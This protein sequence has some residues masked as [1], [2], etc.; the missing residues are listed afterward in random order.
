MIQNTYWNLKKSREFFFFLAV[1]PPPLGKIPYFFLGFFFHPSLIRMINNQ[2]F[3]QRQ[4]PKKIW[5]PHC[6]VD[7]LILIFTEKIWFKPL[8]RARST[9]LSL[10]ILT[11]TLNTMPGPQQVTTSIENIC[12][13]NICIQ[14]KTIPVWFRHSK[15]NF[16]ISQ[17]LSF[18]LNLSA[19]HQLNCVVFFIKKS[20]CKVFNLKFIF[21]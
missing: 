7:V 18:S 2:K 6:S 16:I 3:F 9:F 13:K 19:Q 4:C 10:T 11:L 8:R 15:H 1:T 5:I 17:S 21:I 12:D 20:T 14:T